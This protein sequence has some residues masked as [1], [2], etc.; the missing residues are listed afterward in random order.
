MPQPT[1]TQHPPIGSP[2]FTTVTLTALA[3]AATAAAKAAD[4]PPIAGL[5]KILYHIR[6]CRTDDD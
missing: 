3:A 1:F 6:D 5:S 4:P 2:L